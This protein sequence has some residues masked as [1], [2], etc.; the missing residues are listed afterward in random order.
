MALLLLLTIGGLSAQ[1]VTEYSRQ[2]PPD[3][4][5]S[6]TRFGN[7]P[8][9]YFTPRIEWGRPL[10]TGQLNL[11][12]FLPL[13]AAHESVELASRLD[14]KVDIVTTTNNINPRG[15]WEWF[16][17]WKGDGKYSFYAPIPT[18]QALNDRA[19]VLLSP[20][21]RHNA[22]I[23]GKIKW[24]VIPEDI[25]KGILAKVKGGAALIFVSPRDV[26]ADLQA[27]MNLTDGAKPLSVVAK[28]LAESINATV[29]LA[30]LPLDMDL[31]PLYPDYP[32]RKVGPLEI[33]TGKLGEG[34]VVFLQ[35]NDMFNKEALSDPGG[36]WYHSL[37][38][39]LTP[40][41]DANVDDLFYNYYYSILAKAIIYA[42]GRES[43]GMR[44]RPDSVDTTVA[45]KDLPATPVIFRVSS[46]SLVLPG[47]LLYYE[48]RDRLNNVIAKG[49]KEIEQK[50]DSIAFAP[51][52]PALKQ[53]LYMTDAWIK[54]GGMVLDWASAAVTVT[55][56]S[57]LKSVVAEKEFFG[58]DEGISGNI[59]LKKPVP[60][61]YKV[62]AEL[63]DTYNR[64]EQRVELKGGDP[65]FNFDKIQYPL[66]RAYRIV[67]K[68]ESGDFV[69]DE[70]ETWAGL[71]SNEF[72]EF[73]FIVWGAYSGFSSRSNE[74][75]MILSKEYGVTAYLDG[76]QA[77]FPPS[78]FRQAAYNL[79]KNNIKAW[80]LCAHMAGLYVGEEYKGLG[81]IGDFQK[82]TWKEG[83]TKWF[84]PKIEA[85]KRYGTLAYGIDSESK[86][87]PD[88]AKWNNP[89]AL[90]DYRIYLKGRYGNIDNLNRIWGSVFGSFDD[91][92]LVTFMDARTGRQPTRWLE[93]NL[94]KRDR[95]NSV[96][97]YA[98]GL[99]REFDPGARVGID[100]ACVPL[101]SYDIPRMTKVIDAFIQSD[102]EHFD[103]EKDKSRVSA[104]WW[105]GFYERC[106]T[107][108]HMR[109]KPWESLFRG[110]NA[111]GWWHNKATFT[112]DLSEPLLCFKQASEEIHEIHSGFDRLLMSSDKRLDPI[113]VLWSNNSRVASVY[114]PLE[115]TWDGAIANFIN[116]LRR[117]GIDYQCVGADFIADKLQFGDKQRVLILP[118][119]Q[120]VSRKNVEKIKAF[121]SAG[122]LVVADYM[123]AVMDEY[124]RPYGQDTKSLKSA[125]KF[126]TCPKCKGKKIMHLGGAGDPLGPCPVCGGN[127]K[128]VKGES[129]AMK[130]ALD[131]MFNFTQK[132]VKKYGHGHG[133]FL[134]G[135]P[136]KDE[137]RAIRNT[138][139]KHGGITGNIEVLD[140]L[141]NT[142]T[143]LK[144]FVFD[145][146]PAMFV[147]VLPDSTV[148]AP[149]GEEFILKTDK[150]MHIYNARMQSYLG[151]SD[152]VTAGILPAQA[153]L[154]ALLPARIQ[155]LALESPKT[156]YDP[157]EIV[158]LDIKTLPDTLKAVTL[159]VR[160]ELL[161][162]GKPVEPYTK[163]LAV[164]GA[165]S[166][167]IPLALNQAKGE[168]SVRLTEIISGQRTEMKFEVR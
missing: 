67:C 65:K 21:Y 124:L 14:A 116:M 97:E 104:G 135:S 8:G 133:L 92:G 42:S 39:G 160:I 31:E 167:H 61:G 19:M 119:S 90:R 29:P 70:Q 153:K 68:V 84:L 2:T 165:A 163:K 106:T 69:L 76:I 85:Y 164:K 121:A 82:D 35:Y 75:R 41:V 17:S 28:S 80:P 43:G 113:L 12:V 56:I 30:K 46:D 139:I 10:A 144:T 44:V 157:G 15:N 136:L 158:T 102:L 38:L 159:A 48:I 150:A 54:R 50:D 142:R 72:D 89:A 148:A 134:A 55:D 112:P 57:Y 27:S 109:T 3:Y 11:L 18:E 91:I 108:W 131:E 146:G 40:L 87:S 52:F 145:N 137:W 22:I 1:T 79:A 120:S 122:G 130:S 125:V 49:E 100:I 26:D 59:T 94:Y 64:L 78:M 7:Y 63:W 25:R 93:Q 96:A 141:G 20:A 66:S 71:P 34:N 98:A 5:H 103:K 6:N 101:D 118:A 51:R 129:Q 73:Q 88:D 32:P 81:M 115:T 13:R 154:F 166:H 114:N 132:G 95:F 140:I 83:L 77:L 151:F 74:R 86:I 128:V 147:G 9:S 105:F 126:E 16:Q 45:R 149:P 33:R 62:V 143:D 117:T 37:D 156:D 23:I 24:R 168:Y 127:G 123:P 138:L 152:S 155:G 161:K 58:R 53:G 162:D 47:A 110:G 107:E 36:W 4:K 111:L 60:S 99:V